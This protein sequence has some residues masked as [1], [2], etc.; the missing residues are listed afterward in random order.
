MPLFLIVA[1]ALYMYD[2]RWLK[3]DEYFGLPCVHG[4]LLSVFT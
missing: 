4:A 3:S 1:V 2:C